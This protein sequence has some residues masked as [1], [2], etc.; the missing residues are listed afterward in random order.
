MLPLIFDKTQNMFNRP[1]SLLIVNYFNITSKNNENFAM[2]QCSVIY[3][4]LFS[5]KNSKKNSFKIVCDLQLINTIDLH[6]L[7]LKKT[8]EKDMC[9]P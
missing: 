3:F 9:E 4:T 5:I 6:L 7:S 1:K 8:I 2:E